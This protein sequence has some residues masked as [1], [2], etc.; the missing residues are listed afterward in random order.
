MT[1]LPKLSIITVTFNNRTGLEK[2]INSIRNITH[3]NCEFWIID[4]RSSDSTLEFLN[5][6][7]QHWVHWISEPDDGLYD[8]MNKALNHAPSFSRRSTG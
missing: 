1:S 4:N 7:G 6:T 2:T 8:A 3:E 5:A